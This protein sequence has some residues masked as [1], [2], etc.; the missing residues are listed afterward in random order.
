M[1]TCLPAKALLTTATISARASLLLSGSNAGA[2]SVACQ[3]QADKTLNDK[4]AKLSCLM[5]IG[6]YL[7]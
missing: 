1:G 3:E 7:A 5:I 6:H 2:D 4:A